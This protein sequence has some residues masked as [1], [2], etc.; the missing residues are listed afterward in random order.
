MKLIRDKI[1][2]IMK[3]KGENPKTHTANEE[4]FKH[5][6]TMKLIEE[7]HEYKLKPSAEEL[8]DILEVIHAISEQYGGFD[9]VNE[10]RKKKTAERGNFSKHTVL[11]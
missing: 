8:G 4:E 9:K 11:D 2:E 3:A 7:A 1:P 10:L 5:L 6:L